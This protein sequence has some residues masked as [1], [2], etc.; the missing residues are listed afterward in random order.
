M[1]FSREAACS[2][3]VSM[4]DVRILSVEGW[5]LVRKLSENRDESH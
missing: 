3:T 4:R 5:F 1:I 2:A